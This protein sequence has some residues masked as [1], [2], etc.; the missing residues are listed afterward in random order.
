MSSSRMVRRSRL[1]PGA[2]RAGTRSVR[3][4]VFFAAGAARFFAAIGVARLATLPMTGAA[5]LTVAPFFRADAVFL[6]AVIF[7]TDVV[8][9]RADAVF[10]RAGAFFRA[11]A[12]FVPADRVRPALRRVVA[13]FRGAALRLAAF[14]L[15]MSCSFLR[16]NPVQGYLDSRPISYV[17]SIAYRR[18]T[19]PCRG[20]DATVRPPS[21]VRLPEDG[22]VPT[23]HSPSPL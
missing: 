20:V 12:V 13:A 11:D 19:I 22:A 21:R 7:R 9:F 6:L 15:A 14:R 1:R 4:A 2:V 23:M 16:P 10:L 8:F 3:A 5:R 18:R 17:K